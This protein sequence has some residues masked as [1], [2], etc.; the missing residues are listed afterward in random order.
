MKRQH[1]PSLRGGWPSSR[2]AAVGALLALAFH[3]LHA[4][5]PAPP[6]APTDPAAHVVIVP[7]DV[8]EPLREQKAERFYLDKAAFESLWSLAK[9]NRRPEKAPDAD[10]K[11]AAVIHSALYRARVEDERLVI[12]ARFAV[13]SS[14]KWARLPVRFE[15]DESDDAPVTHDW[16][17]DGR[18][19]AVEEGGLLLESPGAHDLRA[20]IELPRARGW[21]TARLRLPAAEAALVTLSV[22][23]TDG[24]PAL[25]QG[26]FVT[27]ETSGA[28]RS[29]SAVLGRRGVMEIT[30][31]P[32]RPRE[33]A[34]APASADSQ[35][36]VTASQGQADAI[37][38]RMKFD[39]PGT[40]RTRVS[41]ALG[42]DVRLSGWRISPAGRP[43]ETLPL[44]R[45]AVRQ[46][47]GRRVVE[48]ELE[49]AVADG[50][51]ITIAG[52]RAFAAG[53]RATPLLE[54]VAARG[55][56]VLGLVHDESVQV[57]AKP[58]AEQRRIDRP[59]EKAP[60]M[61]NAQGKVS[62][63]YF[64]TKAGQPLVYAIGPAPASWEMKADY[65]FQLSPHKQEM[66]AALALKRARDSWSHLRLGMPEGFEIQSVSGPALHAWKQDGA[67]LHVQWAPG[68]V[69]PEA[70][71]V[72]YLA[73]A[74]SDPQ[75]AWALEPLRVEGFR[76]VEGAALIVAHAAIEARLETL[77]AN[78]DF[79]ESDPAE[80]VTPF[81]ITSPQKVQRGL[82]FE[83]GDW[84]ARVTLERHPARFSAD[85]VAL[86]QATDA[87]LLVSQQVAFRVEG[88]ALGR[89]VVR[90]P[91]ALPEAEVKGESL[92]EVQTRVDGAWRDYD[93]S[94]QTEILNG[95]TLSFD[96]TLPVGAELAVPFVQV[97]GAERLRRYFVLDNSSSRESRVLQAA[98]VEPCEKAALPYVPAVL[99]QPAFYQ[100]KGSDGTLRVGYEELQSSGG[101]AAIVTLA[102]ITTVWRADG[103]R[104]DTVVYSVFNRSMQFLPVI[105]PAKA[106]LIAASVSGQAV[107]ADEKTEA[108][109]RIARLIPLIQTRAGQ[110][111]LEVRLVYRIRDA[112]IP[113]SGASLRLDDPELLG[114]SAERTT[115]TAIV[116]R[117]F[118]IAKSDG[119]MEEVAQE[120][121]VAEQLQGLLA[122]LGRLNRMLS[123]RGTYSYS[124]E[125]GDHAIMEA[126]K[127]VKQ[128]E[129]VSR[130]TVSTNRGKMELL[131]LKKR[132]KLLELD[133]DGDDDKSIALQGHAAGDLAKVRDELGRQ[134][135]ILTE[136]KIEQPVSSTRR[137]GGRDAAQ[138]LQNAWV[139]NGGTLAPEV[140]EFEGFINYGSPIQAGAKDAQGNPTTI[141]LNDNNFVQSDFVNIN[142]PIVRE[143]E[144][145]IDGG[146]GNLAQG[147]ELTRPAD[148]LVPQPGLVFGGTVGFNNGIGVGGVL[149][150]TVG[151]NMET[152][153]SLSGVP[154]EGA[155]A[156]QMIVGGGTLQIQG[157][158]TYT[159]ST[160]INGGTLNVSQIGNNSRANTFSGQ[161]AAAQQAPMPKSEALDLA[162]AQGATSASR[163]TV[164]SG[165]R[166]DAGAIAPDSIDG[167][168]AM[169]QQ[170]MDNEARR[171]M[172]ESLERAG[173]EAAGSGSGG[174]RGGKQLQAAAPAPE[175]AKPQEPP[176]SAADPFAAGPSTTLGL[177]LPELADAKA[178]PTVDL[179]VPAAPAPSLQPPAAPQSAFD[180]P[181]MAQSLG[182]EAQVASQLRATG[183]RSLSLEIP[184]DG[185]P[186]HF[187]K[188]K[189][190]A[191]L[192]LTLKEPWTPS[193]KAQAI[194]LIIGLLFW[195][196]LTVWSSRRKS[197]AAGPVA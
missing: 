34:R 61:T 15:N 106:E 24:S 71:L 142:V 163:G 121:Q 86:A 25:G 97:T 11:P 7:Y 156:G 36:I 37:V 54:P 47:A 120:S 108:D 197:R 6:P 93:C 74:V 138:A 139:F 87:G 8:K 63:L 146:F 180:A 186:F 172:A 154:N 137:A 10:D 177:K 155:S 141:V 179:A 166:S 40:E 91:S 20:I 67:G 183:R 107:R 189:D 113:R 68:V 49:R 21:T 126:E 104:W 29:F 109:G 43:G 38:A 76:K 162:K 117:R 151:L 83:R 3:S 127:L 70:R 193:Q 147:R 185:Q 188:L 95:T 178:K 169:P 153:G 161:I 73:R 143:S 30:R 98:G 4:A 31:S 56:R 114:I 192:E 89:V 118:A 157:M 22:P 195:L 194:I 160:A 39:F 110:R 78:A 145:K 55:R 175:T 27:E 164:I 132:S 130:K 77:A 150:G 19:A 176:M 32:R 184:S 44:R 149:G 14:G 181:E 168:L 136:N 79:R 129:D 51:E 35:L 52:S 75:S 182:I 152:T 80:L 123:S 90:L 196:A 135:I 5:D 85:G 12:E 16:Q 100:G 122:D 60:A 23:A 171:R 187:R 59:E 105:L 33:D 72:V 131:Q 18:A 9:E 128:I 134:T 140:T 82:K 45:W 190:H 65:V 125:E 62:E 165:S 174:F 101:N 158:N 2:P 13:A 69:L 48:F 124:K 1:P 26:V 102:D 17:V 46:E 103:E 148:L 115:W 170:Q 41:A 94:F 133:K 50:C 112:A 144:V 66:M 111:S 191:V 99:A 92:R 88:G 173:R 64:Q 81:T 53:E 84:S 159:G 42:D 116:P 119:N 58:G 28:E 96:I 167:L 57:A